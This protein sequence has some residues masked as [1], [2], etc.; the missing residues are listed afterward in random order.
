M[1][2]SLSE[3]KRFL[4]KE[5]AELIEYEKKL[6]NLILDNFS[7]VES[8][9]TAAG[10]R[11]KLVAKLI[12]DAGDIVSS[13]LEI[14]ADTASNNSNKITHLSGIKVQDF[15]GFSNEQTLEFKNLYTFIYG[16]NGTGKSSLCEA[17]EYSLLGSINEA[18]AKRIEV[19]AYIKNSI[20]KKSNKPILTGTT[21]SGDKVIVQP[22]SKS[23]EFCFIEKNRIDGFARVAA[24]TPQAQQTRLAA[25][26]GLEE[27]NTFSTQFNDNFDKYL[28][29]VG[30][31]TKELADK[32]KEIAGQK[33][34]LLQLPEKEAEVKAKQDALILKYPTCNALEE[35]KIYI[36]G[37]DGTAG[38]LKENNTEIGRLNNLK[39]ATDPEIDALLAE[40]N[41]LIAL[42][43]EGRTAT[44]FL[45]NYKDQLSLGGLY[46]AILN[47]QEKYKNNCP[48]CESVLYEDDALLVPLDP[49]QHA[50]VKLKEFDVA[51]KKEA[52][53]KEIA[54]DLLKRWPPLSQ[55]IVNL[56][57]IATD[58]NFSRLVEL[59]MLRDAAVSADDNKS[60]ATALDL[61]LEKSELLSTLKTAIQ[62]F[63]LLITQSKEKIKNLELANA[64]L[65]KQLEEIVE[66]NTT[67]KAHK[68]SATTANGAI[69][70][71]NT[72][73]EA[74]IKQ[75]E[76]EK[77][78][79]ARNIKY[80]SAYSGFREKLL[81]YNNNL[82]L[83][84]AADLNEKTLKFYNAIN[85]NDHVSDRLKSLTLPTSTGMKIEIEFGGG[86]K[87]DA[88]QVLS[89]GH[90]RCL[91]LAI[92]LSKIVRDG[93]PFLIFDDVVNSI[94]DEH[95]G[96]IIDLILGDE[97][98]KNKQL[99]ITT[100]GEDFVKRLENA[101][102]KRD[103]KHTVSRIDFLVPIDSKKIQVKLDLP[104]HYLVVAE[105]SY[106]D[107]KVRDSLSYLRKSFEEL[108]N[109]LW[110]KIANKTHNVQ[111]QLGLRGPNSSPDLMG[112]ANGLYGFLSK[113]EVSIYQDVMPML[114]QMLGR[115]HTH[116]VEWSYL[117][118][119][120][121]EEDR[122]EEFDAAIVKE[123]LELVSEIDKAIEK[124][125]VVIPVATST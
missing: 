102:P 74:L 76:E 60:R 9:G 26:F 58:I 97:E 63:N 94:D 44:Q 21:A 59:E 2:K 8:T 29:C 47:N 7:R 49:Y 3:F 115:E 120:T 39:L 122:D 91:G 61:F 66:L 19:S 119:G 11:G 56:Y 114:A 92:L 10:S 32:E 30:K 89:E 69:E 108:L 62:D 67:I 90:I 104:R 55:K 16:P 4:G 42:I 103:Y 51:L 48:A 36:S 35:V 25:L 50:R 86:E 15:R 17:L 117:N 121:H 1:S 77:P 38:L 87:C 5:Q 52:R 79:V 113:K 112:L 72:E 111:I 37:D 28:D 27:F 31:K 99:I 6:A 100:H 14:V 24:N 43:Q 64:A 95:R 34:I 124:G 57:M 88:L 33:V 116:T 106:Q 98:I 96:G 71:F 82:P 84:L 23:Y 81:K 123:M 101:I 70:K 78:V 65:T 12:T 93:L 109:R 41:S 80:V 107:G 85:K 73:N 125:D 118:K 75:A 46:E 40:V 83:S 54:D 53:I 105:Q 68:T 18:D 20:T 13:D 22:D 110:K 45:A